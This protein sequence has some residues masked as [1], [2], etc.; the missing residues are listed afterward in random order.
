MPPRFVAGTP[1]LVAFSG[2]P[3]AQAEVL[4]QPQVRRDVDRD[5]ALAADFVV[6]CPIRYHRLSLN[7]SMASRKSRIS[8]RRAA[9]SWR[10]ATAKG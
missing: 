3:P 9:T 7:N 4:E 1:L 8:D 6:I 2:W 5:Q 10:A